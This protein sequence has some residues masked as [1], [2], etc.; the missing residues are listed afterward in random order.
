[1]E[2][3]FRAA[4]AAMAERIGQLETELA[5]ARAEL[6]EVLATIPENGDAYIRRLM[7]ENAELQAE[8]RQLARESALLRNVPDDAAK[9]RSR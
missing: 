3:P 8:C 7:E 6:V 9:E 2:T 5:R 1:V 4:D